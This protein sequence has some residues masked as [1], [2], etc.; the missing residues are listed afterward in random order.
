MPAEVRHVLFRPTEVVSAIADYYRRMQMPLP[1]GSVVRS[2]VEDENGAVRFTMVVS[3]D[4]GSARQSVTLEGSQLAAA[5]ILFCRDHRV[6]L[7]SD[8]DKSLKKLDDWLAL[9]VTR[10]PRQEML[11]GIR[12]MIPSM[13]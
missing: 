9:V 3:R 12:L 10:N 5:L 11:P 7:P 6:P 4:D 8:S 13:A 1:P 2:A